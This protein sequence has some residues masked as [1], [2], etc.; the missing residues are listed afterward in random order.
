MI[1]SFLRASAFTALALCAALVLNQVVPGVLVSEAV[2][3][4]KPKKDTRET[5]RTP[6]LRNKVYE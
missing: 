6:A 2:A 5:R 1:V 3:Q 4:D